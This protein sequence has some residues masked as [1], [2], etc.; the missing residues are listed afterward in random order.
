VNKIGPARC[1]NGGQRSSLSLPADTPGPLAKGR[2]DVFQLW[3]NGVLQ[4]GDGSPDAGNVKIN[5]P[6]P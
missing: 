6:T 4:S 2:P 5:V 1:S 3:V